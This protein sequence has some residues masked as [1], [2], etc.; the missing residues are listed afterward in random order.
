[1]NQNRTART[2]LWQLMKEVRE[3]STDAGAAKR[4]RIGR[5]A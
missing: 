1:L 5:R 2:R 4:P 3:N